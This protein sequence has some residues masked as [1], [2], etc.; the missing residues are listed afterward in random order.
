MR[1]LLAIDDSECSAAAVHAVIAQFAPQHS[2]VFV[3]HA[4]EWPKALPDAMAFAEGSAAAHSILG[5]HELRRRDAGALVASA[6]A[7]LRAAGFATTTTIREGDARQVI[8]ASAGE[9]HADLIV[10]GSHG[11]TGFDRLILGSVSDGVAGHAPCSVEIVRAA[12]RAA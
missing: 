1:I 4:D 2:E 9:W 3:L 8:L 5:L 12:P 7:Q 10:L 6:A 11:R